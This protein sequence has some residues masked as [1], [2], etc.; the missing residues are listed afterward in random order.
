MKCETSLLDWNTTIVRLSGCAGVCHFG[1]HTL[2]SRLSMTLNAPGQDKFDEKDK[3]SKLYDRGQRKKP[4][5]R[6]ELK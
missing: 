5:T 4:T 3:L 1:S 2:H 6:L